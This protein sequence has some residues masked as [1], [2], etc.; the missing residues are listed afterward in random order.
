MI[1]EE[2]SSE[3]VIELDIQM[4]KLEVRGEIENVKKY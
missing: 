3:I 2:L 4:D 1:S